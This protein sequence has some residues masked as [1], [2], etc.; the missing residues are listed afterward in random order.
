VP[1]KREKQPLS[2]THPELAKEADGW[3]PSIWVND[4]KIKMNWLCVNGHKYSS[5]IKDR[6]SGYGC[7]VCGREKGGKKVESG[8]NDLA[9]L[10]PSIASEAV[11][12]EPSLFLPK[13]NK[14]MMWECRFG[15]SWIASLSERTSGKGC[16]YCSGRRVIVGE[17]DLMTKYPEIAVQAFGWNPQEVSSS[18][19]KKLPWKCI[20]DHI[21]RAAVYS[22]KNGNGC[23]YCSGNLPIVGETDLLTLS[24]RLAQ[25]ADGWDPREF[26]N[27][28]GKKVN[29]K[30]EQ[31][32]KSTSTIDNRQKYGCPF[33]SG[34]YPIKGE[35][36]LRT[37]FPKI[38]VEADG[39]NPQDF[40]PKSNQIKPW[41]CPS[42]HKYKAAIATRTDS[43][44][45]G[46]GCPYCS[47]RKVISGETDLKT[48]NPILASEAYGWDPSEVSPGS[49]KK[50]SWKCALGHV[51]EAVVY[52]RNANTGCPYCANQKVLKG[53]NDLATTH[54]DLAKEAVD[55]DPSTVTSGSSRLNLLWKCAEGHTWKSNVKNRT[56]GQGCP[57]C[58]VSGFDPN[59]DGF[60][61][62][63]HHDLWEMFQIG[64]TN[65]P[66]KRLGQ[67]KRLGWIVL[68]L[69]GP[70]DGHLT[71]QWETGMLR[72]LKA[73]GADL[74][75]DKIAGKFD[76]YSEAWSKS[77]FQVKS[78]KEL[79]GMTEEFEED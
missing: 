21:W 51:W 57:S 38:A 8:I 66:D 48:M 77:T 46:N 14:K 52:S 32:H 31:G 76:G 55:W 44:A 35:T 61:Y 41:I 1:T 54:P 60:L 34:K 6:R 10:F 49:E 63:I 13:S 72:M 40:L 70:M 30:C 45:T 75:N 68:E 29:W 20:N 65:D 64:I 11:G 25:D 26:T 36:D 5:F 74:S 78:I 67:H 17:T 56:V 18:S 12:W 79:M 4:R 59:K 33:C 27:H 2:V 3:D 53:F 9:T 24:P 50:L 23:P 22:R 71:Q 43:R 19:G 73:K 37:K 7:P 15:H 69:R 42:G 28:S 62:F 39:W 16:P 47:G 58:A